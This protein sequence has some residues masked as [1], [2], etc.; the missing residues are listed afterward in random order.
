MEKNLKL[1]WVMATVL[2]TGCATQA[3]LSGSEVASR[4]PEL[5]SLQASL[6]QAKEEQVS[7]LAPSLY[8]RAKKQLERADG[9]AAEGSQKAG[10]VL[11]EASSLLQKATESTSVAKDELATV[12]LARDRA[13]AAGADRRF[14][15][16]F[17][18]AEKQLAK[19]GDLIASGK[20]WAV[21][22][23]RQAL[24]QSYVSLEVDSL[25]TSTA[26]EAADMIKQAIAAEADEYAPE[27]LKK[28][29]E[30][31][32]LSRKVLETDRTATDKAAARAQMSYW[33]AKRALQVTEIIKEIKQSH[34]SDEQVVLWYQSQLSHAVAPVIGKLD[35]SMSNK[36][37]ISHIAAN[38]ETLKKQSSDVV[39]QLSQTQTGS[40]SLL[41]QK[42]A[43]Y[44]AKLQE[45][46]TRYLQ[47]LERKDKELAS[48]QSVIDEKRKR[49]EEINNTFIGVQGLFGEKEAEVYRQG[50][51]VLIRA[52]GFSFPSGK[53]EIQSGNFPLLNKIIQAVQ[54]FP[55]SAVEV[56]GH[57]DNRGSDSFNMKL[58]DE[59]ARKVG[60]FLVDVG[61]IE[62]RRVSSKGYGKQKPLASNETAE[63]RAAN[64]RVE[65]LIVNR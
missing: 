63:G 20:L 38:L 13:I 31:L 50:N 46:E 48:L 25:K 58:S 27:T 29:Q 51:N 22:E 53:S 32:N 2:A 61:N 10:S 40:A 37:V 52:Y 30:E 4:Y 21:R 17:Q 11:A 60:R 7:L 18:S 64:R 59:R 55:G 35:F 6:A 14:H 57:T 36:A 28:A 19:M 54:L 1:A 9:L 33:Y 47:I 23:D 15:K 24:A 12:L 26:A 56:S 45:A 16:R 5:A 42:E 34:M 44:N 8:S 65:I 62:S 39:S 49:E 41:A 43:E 3:Q